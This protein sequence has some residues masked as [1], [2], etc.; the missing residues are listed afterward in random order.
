MNKH[1]FSLFILFSLFG[2]AFSENLTNENL[3]KK[4]VFENGFVFI[5]KPLTN[6]KMITLDLFIKTGIFDEEIP[7]LAYLTHFSLLDAQKKFQITEKIKKLGGE[8]KIIFTEDY[9][10]ISVDIPSQYIDISLE[11]IEDI[12]KN[13]LFEQEEIQ[14]EKEKILQEIKKEKE[15]FL[16]F[17]YDLFKTNIYK[18]HPYARNIKGT[19]DS[20][21]IITRNDIL[22]YWQKY[23]VPNKMILVAVGDF[24]QE[25]LLIKT[26]NIFGNLKPIENF[27]NKN[28]FL[29]D[30]NFLPKKIEKKENTTQ[31]YIVLGY[32][33]SS[34]INSDYPVLKVI[35]MLLA[36]EKKSRLYIAFCEKR[37]IAYSLGCYFPTRKYLSFFAFNVITKE[38]TLEQCFNGLLDELQKI[39]EEKIGIEELE[40]TKKNLIDSF[41][42]NHQNRIKQA[43]Y[44]GW[45]E[46]LDIG[47][48]FDEKYCDLIRKVSIQD[49]K[50]VAEKYFKAYTAIIIKSE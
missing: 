40:E 41:E 32:L 5:T 1:I 9:A 30:V 2:F 26:N 27:E 4:T 21:K 15:N 44:L 13:P 16:N 39:K 48:E 38:K 42:R 25:N 33:V 36:I 43:W 31:A 3:T 34:I 17:A 14:N 8:I 35:E 24:S 23:Y 19:E 18:N 11:I 49:I 12:I 37:K 20:I 10:E 50:K 6:T 45:F 22:N 28:Y 46:V 47:Y 7:G 29:S